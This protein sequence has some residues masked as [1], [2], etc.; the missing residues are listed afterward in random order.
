MLTNLLSLYKEVGQV[1]MIAFN[2]AM[3][4]GG[5]EAIVES[6]Y[7]VMDTQKLVRQHHV[8]LEAQSILGWPRVMFLILKS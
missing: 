2:I 4:M 1:A 7:S 8:T 3:S 6:F 5:S